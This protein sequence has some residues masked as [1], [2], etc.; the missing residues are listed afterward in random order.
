MNDPRYLAA[1]AHHFC[2]A[3]DPRSRR[4]AVVLRRL[5]AQL[6]GG[7]PAYAQLLRKALAT[8]AAHTVDV[9]ALSAVNS[10]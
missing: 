7:L 1:Q 8:A 5:A 4:P 6:A 2:L 3:S 10:A 9:G